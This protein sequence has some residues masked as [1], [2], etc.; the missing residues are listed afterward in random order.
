MGIPICCAAFFT[1]VFSPLFEMAMWSRGTPDD[2]A[3]G[4][5]ERLRA[6]LYWLLFAVWQPPGSQCYVRCPW[7]RLTKRRERRDPEVAA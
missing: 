3:R 5:R 2:P 1:V 4:L 7:H 6:F